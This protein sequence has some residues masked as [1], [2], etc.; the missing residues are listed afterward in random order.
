[1]L[2]LLLLLLLLMIT[3]ITAINDQ[4][5]TSLF[6]YPCLTTTPHFVRLR[7]ALPTKHF[8]VTGQ[9]SR[10][11][12]GHSLM[13]GKGSWA[14]W[15]AGW[16]HHPSITS[17]CPSAV[18]AAVTRRPTFF[19]LKSLPTTPQRLRLLLLLL[20]LLLLFLLPTLTLVYVT[21]FVFVVQ[22]SP[23]AICRSVKRKRRNVC[24]TFFRSG[25]GQVK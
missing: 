16:H 2:L 7:R 9:L 3:R 20:L 4:R 19:P 12:E 21:S 6:I 1:M 25:S 8:R 11:S 22:L 15:L 17:L 10:G 14:G 13:A 5:S 18:A 23:T 24:H